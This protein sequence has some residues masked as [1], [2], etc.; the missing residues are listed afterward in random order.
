MGAWGRLGGREGQGSKG[1]ERWDEISS[2]ALRGGAEKEV[3]AGGRSH[4]AVV[5]AMYKGRGHWQE[6]MRGAPLVGRVYGESGAMQKEAWLVAKNGF[7]GAEQGPGKL[8]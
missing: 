5:V 8:V 3:V 1:R 6:R 4:S 7:K 2:I